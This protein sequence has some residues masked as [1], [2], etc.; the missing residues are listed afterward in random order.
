MSKGTPNVEA[1]TNVMERH[2]V[3]KIARGA[4][5]SIILSS[6]TWGR[7]WLRRY[8]RRPSLTCFCC[9]DYQ[10]VCDLATIALVIF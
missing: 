2:K 7:L 3:G 10:S 1:T 5:L 9:S 8:N 6:V 4:S